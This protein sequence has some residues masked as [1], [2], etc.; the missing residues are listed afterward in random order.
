[1][2]TICLSNAVTIDIECRCCAGSSLAP[3]RPVRHRSTYRGACAFLFFPEAAELPA[4]LRPGDPPLC[5]S[6]GVRRIGDRKR[7][8]RGGETN[9]GRLGR[10]ARLAEQTLGG[11]VEKRGSSTQPKR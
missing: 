6:L 1:M 4:N 7:A 11:A 9:R 3:I 2:T 5:R 10:K 8:R